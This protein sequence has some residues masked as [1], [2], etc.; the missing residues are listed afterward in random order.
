MT[1]LRLDDMSESLV[2]AVRENR[3]DPWLH[4]SYLE[5]KQLESRLNKPDGSDQEEEMV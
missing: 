4:Y 5:L 1:S 3:D 2:M